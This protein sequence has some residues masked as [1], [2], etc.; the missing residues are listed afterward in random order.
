MKKRNLLLVLI[1]LMIN[2]P[3]AVTQTI[4]VTKYENEVY[5]FVAGLNLLM[6]VYQPE[7]SNHLGIVYIA[8][9]G[10]GS[11]AIW[12][13]I[14]LK[15]AY[16]D[17]TYAGLWPQGL[18]KKG[19]TVFMIN[20]S[21][22]P[23]FHFPDI[24]FDCQRA[25]RYVRYHAKKYDIYPDKIGVMGHST[26]AYLSSM[27]GVKDTIIINPKNEIDQVSSRV[28]AVVALAAPF[29]LSDNNMKSDTAIQTS[30][31]R[32]VLMDYMGELPEAKNGE[33]I[34]SGK[35]AA[36][37]P[38][39]YISND[40]AAFLIYYSDNDP[41]IPPRQAQRYYNNLEGNKVQA[42]IVVCHNCKH[43]PIPDMDE[44]D[45]W[46]KKYLK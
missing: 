18:L 46:F 19:Y 11:P 26:G 27:L 21:F 6:D 38:I 43:H 28:Q 2:N 39:T 1:A 32:R 30:L 3:K 5:G 24:L 16:Y 14:P 17:S 45:R 31:M 22:A 10:W 35:Y 20:H 37:S 7:N 29:I 12:N 13:D 33:F 4:K 41:F 25:V 34:L 40:D 15:D 42:K 23:R 8:G 36:A 44:V 9:S